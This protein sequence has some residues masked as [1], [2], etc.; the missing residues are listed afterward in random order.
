[1]K[2]I[3]FKK[4]SPKIEEVP[5]PYCGDKELLVRVQYS[6][7]SPG[8][9]RKQMQDTETGSIIQSAIAQPQ[10]LTKAMHMLC[11][12]GVKQTLK[13]VKGELGLGE[14]SGYSISGIVEKTGKE[15]RDFSPGDRVA[16]A[17]AANA[18]HAEYAAI[19]SLLA[20]KVPEG[21][22]M[23]HAATVALGAIA[24][25]GV[26]RSEVRLGE[27]V[28][29]VGLGAL[30]LIAGLLLKHAG[31]RVFG[32]DLS[33]NR[34]KLAKSAG[35]KHVFDPNAS[36][37]VTRI[38]TLTRGNGMDAVI[39]AAASE[40]EKPIELAAEICRKKGKV[41]MVGS[42][43]LSLQRRQWYPKELDFYMSTSYGPGRYDSAYE[44]LGKDYPYAYVRWTENRIMEAYLECIR[45]GLDIASLIHAIYP[46]A[47]AVRAF[48]ETGEEVKK[49]P[50]K[51]IE[52]DNQSRQESSIIQ[53]K[54]IAV[55]DKMNLAIIGPGQFAMD[56]HVPNIKRLSKLFNIHTVMDVSGHT[57]KE[58]AYKCNAQFTTTDF[59]AVLD[60]DDIHLLL[61]TTRHNL[62]AE[63]AIQGARAGAYLGM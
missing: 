48:Q 18:F 15:I 11:D 51:I 10:K 47:E 35:I 4:G 59:Q 60:N 23:S 44:V 12:E 52:Y 38:K 17:G 2:Q 63:Y 20:V 55:K 32:F 37:Q 16:C 43:K 3:F 13:K 26:Q 5:V 42:T 30:G 46:L 39:I 22:D 9:E 31:C 34:R 21:V 49:P 58:I 36:R 29:V 28:A 33:P 56:M 62:H 7:I 57:A 25:H 19:P 50:L 61:I 27:S 1:M 41:V 8:T 6:C 14:V 24:L 53:L 54:T 45:E 40:N